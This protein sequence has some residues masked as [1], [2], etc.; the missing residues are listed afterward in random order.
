M[1]LVPVRRVVM[2]VHLVRFSWI[3][4]LV[5]FMNMKIKNDIKPSHNLKCC[6]TSGAM[7]DV[8]DETFGPKDIFDTLFSNH[9][10]VPI[11]KNKRLGGG[12]YSRVYSVKY[13]DKK[14]AVKSS[15]PFMGFSSY[16][17]CTPAH[18]LSYSE[19]IFNKYNTEDGMPIVFPRY[20]CVYQPQPLVSYYDDV[21]IQ[22]PQN[23]LLFDN[24][25]L[26]EY[27]IGRLATKLVEK[28]MCIHFVDIYGIDHYIDPDCFIDDYPTRVTANIY[29]EKI[30]CSLILHSCVRIP[31]CYT[32]LHLYIF[33]IMFAIAS[34]QHYF[35][36]SHNDLSPNN[37]F[38][39]E[40]AKMQFD[41]NLLSDAEYFHYQI[42]KKNFYLPRTNYIIKIGDWGLA[43]K[44]RGQVIG[45]GEFLGLTSYRT[46]H[47]TRQDLPNW[48]CPQYD[49][50]FLIRCLDKICPGSTSIK[51][52]RE[53]ILCETGTTEFG[54]QDF[55]CYN[56]PTFKAVMEKFVNST[57]SNALQDTALMKQYCNV[58]NMPKIYT[59]RPLGTHVTLGYI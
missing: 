19:T 10:I 36:I 56:R 22:I 53:W 35:N 33:Q 11:S 30:T 9:S 4:K 47:K 2:A 32:D 51:I 16:S 43:T 45:D 54:L 39:V 17:L 42:G 21:A 48:W 40:T 24:M 18:F 5:I 58:Y 26:S 49:F 55:T 7:A 29:M 12:N 50:V 15:L 14:C 6:D 59:K 3:R 41:G 52:L 23:S 31:E 28:G 34:Y 1:L 27:L 46:M 38:L 13:D 57:A 20:T 44:W 8:M 37:I 25:Y